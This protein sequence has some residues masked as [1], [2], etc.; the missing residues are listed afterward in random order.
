ML[1]FY[2]TI[3]QHALLAGGRTEQ[4][5]FPPEIDNKKLNLK[6]SFE[7]LR[8]IRIPTLLQSHLE[9]VSATEKMNDMQIS[10][11]NSIAEEQSKAVKI[12][13]LTN[14]SETV[15]KKKR[16]NTLDDD[17]RAY[18]NEVFDWMGFMSN[19]IMR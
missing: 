1:L 6:E 4:I 5:D 16:K 10:D 9:T 13:E 14:R 12:G 2:L 11:N 15:R 18:L 7:E 3:T 17:S 19:R 8:N